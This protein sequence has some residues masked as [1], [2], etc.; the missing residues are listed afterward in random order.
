MIRGK[1]PGRLAF[2]YLLNNCGGVQDEGGCNGGDFPA[3]LNMLNG[4]GPWLES[5][6]PYQGYQTS[7]RKGLSPAGSAIAW[8]FVGD[9]KTAPTFRDLAGAL[10][11][12]HT[13][14]VDI[15]ACHEWSNYSGGIFN[16]N[17]CGL[18]QIDHMINLVG[19]NC[20]TSVDP[21]GNCVF[22]AKE[23][24]TNGDGYLI[25]MNNWGT[26]WGEKGYMR[27]RWGMNAIADSAMYFE[28]L[29]PSPTPSLS[30][31]PNPNPIPGTVK[32]TWF[33]GTS[34]GLLLAGI[35]IGSLLK[36]FLTEFSTRQDDKSKEENQQ[37]E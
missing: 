23:K 36:R 37:S 21:S 28:V 8:N 17:E 32:W 3:G 2:N 29:G 30:P 20:E 1:D 14:T 24:P 12:G 10:S 6:D 19:Y 33:F 34:L 9:G 35:V 11:A 27:T 4:K 25:A 18:S 5:Q 22:D 15:A 16:R 13:L 7:C 31:T 26:S